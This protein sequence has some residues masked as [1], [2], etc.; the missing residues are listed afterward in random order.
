MKRTL[1]V[2]LSL[3]L[4]SAVSS[5]EVVDRIAAVVNGEIILLSEVE[6]A[7]G[8]GLPPLD[9]KG[10]DA[11]RRQ[12]LLERAVNELVSD[13]LVT[14]VAKEQGLEPAPAEIDGAIDNV[15]RENRIDQKGLEGALAQQGMTM[16]TYR[17][18]LAK[19]LTRMKVAEVKVRPRVNVSEDDVRRRYNEMTRG[20]ATTE[21][22]H[23][24]DVFLPADGDPEAARAKAEDARARAMAGESFEQVARDAGGPLADDGGDLGWVGKDAILPELEDTAFSLKKG[25]ISKVIEAA[26]GYHVL[27]VEDVRTTGSALSLAESRDE[28]R[29]QLFAE[30]MAKATEEWLGEIRRTADVEVRIR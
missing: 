22:R 24:R 2:A 6:A 29:G 1:G 16:A 21:E 4:V 20:M 12:A 7:A 15:M 9:A 30:R 14:E 23:V 27:F 3:L 10:A 19:Q 8:P 17:E 18:M 13:E 28:I 26:G 25:E 5:A 11:Q